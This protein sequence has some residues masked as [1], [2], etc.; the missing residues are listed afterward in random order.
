M[1]DKIKNIHTRLNDGQITV[2]QATELVMVLFN[3]SK[4]RG[5]NVCGKPLDN[6]SKNGYCS[7]ECYNY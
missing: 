4:V 2:S 3:E 1:K 7:D 6:G 5:C